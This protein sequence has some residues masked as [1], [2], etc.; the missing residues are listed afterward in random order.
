MLATHLG[1][2]LAHGTLW[3][4]V[5]AFLVR[6]RDELRLEQVGPIIDFVHAVRHRRL[7]VPGIDGAIVT[8]VEPPE[9]GFS[10]RGRTLASLLR[11][12]K[13]WHVESNG[14][15]SSGLSWNRSRQR[16]MLVQER[17]LDPARD[18]IVWELVELTTGHELKVEG[19]AR[20]HCV[21]W[22]ASWCWRGASRIW[23][24]RRRVGS[25]AAR[26]FVTIEVDP[27]TA[28]IVQARGRYNRRPSSKTREMIHA[29]ARRESL[30][31]KA[32][33]C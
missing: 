13:E 21:A 19:R 25:G 28:T 2:D 8:V 1:R 6:F 16:P 27:L 23:S 14:M 12:V 9:P 3:R 22:Y 5:L 24:L 32:G 20:S 15:S 17:S 11:L 33:A 18:P 30:H 7:E 10:V 29:W 4:T 31:I 26:P